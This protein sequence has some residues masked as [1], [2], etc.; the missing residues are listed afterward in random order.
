MVL[1][2]IDIYLREYS[3]FFTVF[4]TIN[5]PPKNCDAV[6]RTETPSVIQSASSC[7]MHFIL[8]LL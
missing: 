2:I 8:I 4:L 3:D 6:V 1:K 7:E 5:E